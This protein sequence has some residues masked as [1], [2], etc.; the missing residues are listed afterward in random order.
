MKEFYGICRVMIGKKQAVQFMKL[1]LTILLLSLLPLPSVQATTPLDVL[2]WWTSPGEHR[3]A[4]VLRQDL[5]QHSVIWQDHAV[6]GGGGDSAMAVLKAQVIAG[7]PPDVAQIIGPN[8]GEWA[9][10]GYLQPLD[11]WTADWPDDWHRT[12]DE[13][14]RFN[15]ERVAVPISI[16]RINWMWLNPQV[17]QELGLSLPTSW[18]QIMR[19]A[20]TLR[21]A[22]ITPLAHGGQ[23]WQVATLFETLL[24]SVGGPEFY[25]DYF[26]YRTPEALA[27][28]R[29]E[30]A[31]HLL[32]DLKTLMDDEMQNR[33]WQEASRMVI[34]GEAAMQIMGDWVKGEFVAHSMEAGQDFLCMPVPGTA[35]H[36]L[37][38]VDTFVFFQ[39]QDDETRAAQ[40]R[41]A[42]GIMDSNTQRQF[43]LQKGTIPARANVDLSGFDDCAQTSAHVFREAE[44]TGLLAPSMAHSM[45]TSPGVE[46]ALFHVL[47]RFFRDDDIPVTTAREQMARVLGALRDHE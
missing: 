8:I 13:L 34:E 42:E 47:H 7:S 23:P 6:P 26:V 36:H 3:A 15:G 40:A 37:Y 14:T 38:S 18:S 28:S 43:S 5:L 35:Q 32:R 27:D 2:H 45:A 24:L 31:L 4:E 11:E 46:S 22:G 12:L 16:H 1:G 44:A 20:E 41:F 21:A 25:R 19:D 17:Y 9:N 10:L 30:E 33:E 29:V 39:R